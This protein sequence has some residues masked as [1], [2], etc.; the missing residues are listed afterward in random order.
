MYSK[1][2]LSVLIVPYYVI[3]DVKKNI[4]TLRDNDTSI[5]KNSVIKIQK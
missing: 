2:T 3:K 1:T 5:G 4:Q